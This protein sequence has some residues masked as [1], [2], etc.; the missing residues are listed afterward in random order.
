MI[1]KIKFSCPVLISKLENHKE[2]NRNLLN[3]FDH[4]P[5]QTIELD[6]GYEIKGDIYPDSFAK[7]DWPKCNDY[8]RPWVDYFLPELHGELVRMVRSIFFHDVNFRGIWFQQYRKNNTHGWHIHAENYTGVY[9]VELGDD[10][11]Q[12]QII[13]PFNSREIYTMNVKE[14]DILIFPSF[15]VHRAPPMLND[16]RKTIVSFN[17]NFTKPAD[18]LYQNKFYPHDYIRRIRK[19]LGWRSI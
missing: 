19:F 10:S 13:N 1:K 14:G 9:Y 17:F 12:T 4:C 3:Y 11:P 2:I 18:D 16:T 5:G 8:S 6:Q 7:L 15:F